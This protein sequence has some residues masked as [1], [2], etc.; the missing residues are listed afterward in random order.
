MLNRRFAKTHKMFFVLAITLSLIWYLPGWI[1][2]GVDMAAS[3][4]VADFCINPNE[5]VRSQ[6]SGDVNL[7]NYYLTCLPGAVNPLQPTIDAAEQGLETGVAEAGYLVIYAQSTG[8]PE[9]ISLAN[10]INDQIA[11]TKQDVPSLVEI[12]NCPKMHSLYVA[13]LNGLCV[14]TLNAVF[15]LSITQIVAGAS[16]LLITITATSLEKYYDIQAVCDDKRVPLLTN[17]PPKA[18]F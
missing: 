3:V 14:T 1:V 6:V 15:T 16:L 13:G 11:A 10:N 9:L 18:L 2:S 12:L 8:D 4:G 17:M 7:L 5:F